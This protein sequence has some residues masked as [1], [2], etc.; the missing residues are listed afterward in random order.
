MQNLK[1]RVDN[2]AILQLMCGITSFADAD[3]VINR[4]DFL[5]IQL[6]DIVEIYHPEDEF[7]R[8]LLQVTVFKE[9]LQ[10]KGNFV[11]SSIT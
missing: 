9:D 8:L 11:Y 6:N 3:L 7:S 2:T 10:G 4:K 5:D 1:T